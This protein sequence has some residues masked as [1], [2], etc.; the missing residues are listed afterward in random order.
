MHH[1]VPVRTIRRR[2][3]QSGISARGPLF[4]LPLNGNHRRLRRQRYDELQTW[5][6]ELNNI[7]FTDESHI[8]FLPWTACSPDLS[9]IEN[10][11][12]MLAQRLDEDTPPAPTPDKVWQYVES[13][14]R[15]CCS[16]KIL[17]KPL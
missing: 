13:A 12:S 4:H 17:S 15:D 2:L 6:K 7:V 1:L 14:C 8:E 10:V 3:Q 11:W 5:T 16:P 9:P